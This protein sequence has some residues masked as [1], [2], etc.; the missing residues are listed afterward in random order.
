MPDAIQISDASES[1]KLAY[2]ESLLKTKTGVDNSI[3]LLKGIIV[4]SGDPDETKTLN[5][6]ILDLEGESN[7]L[8]AR[9]L[10]F[11]AGS[12]KFHPPSPEQVQTIKDIVDELDAMTADAQLAR[13]IITTSAGLLEQW[14][15]ISA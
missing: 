3:S 15:E 9:L 14:N 10:A 7:K 4:N 8:Q 2:L 5:I 13:T 12:A 6:R 1:E 11:S